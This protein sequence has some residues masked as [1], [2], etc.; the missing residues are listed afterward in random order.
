MPMES[1]TGSLENFVTT[2]QREE[3]DAPVCH[4][5]ADGRSPVVLTTYVHC[6]SVGS[7]VLL[8]TV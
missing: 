6:E 2:E 8:G 1:G 7:F 4:V 5:N 3:D